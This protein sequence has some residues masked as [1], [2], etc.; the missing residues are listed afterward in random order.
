M[1]AVGDQMGISAGRDTLPGKLFPLRLEFLRPV[2]VLFHQHLAPK[3]SRC[4][5]EDALRL[6]SEGNI[7]AKC[8]QLALARFGVERHF[9]RIDSRNARNG[10]GDE[11]ADR[12]TSP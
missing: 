9:R 3:G 10:S 7:D 6:F 11:M 12:S 1:V 8:G 5:L 4:I 2:E